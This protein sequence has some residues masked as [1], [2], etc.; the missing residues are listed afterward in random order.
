MA[1]RVEDV[2]AGRAEYPVKSKQFWQP[3]LAIVAP[4]VEAALRENFQ[5]VSVGGA[6]VMILS[7]KLQSDWQST[8]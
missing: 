5:S 8:I 7:D 1:A 3:D 4:A 6:V 2:V